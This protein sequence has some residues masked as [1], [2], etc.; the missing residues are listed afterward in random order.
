MMK[1]V[2]AE[3]YAEFDER[4]RAVEAERAESDELEDL[5]ILTAIENRRADPERD[6]DGHLPCCGGHQRAGQQVVGLVEDTMRSNHPTVTDGL[7]RR[8]T[9]CRLPA[10]CSD[11]LSAFRRAC[12][13]VL[14][15][16]HAV[17]RRPSPAPGRA[18]VD[19]SSFRVW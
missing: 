17:H 15:G 7:A 19:T 1:A 6:E 3:R 14:Q 4:R 2:A 16:D 13:R 5:R 11:R 8:R 18:L 10:H 9:R 12:D